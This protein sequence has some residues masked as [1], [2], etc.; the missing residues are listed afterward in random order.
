MTWLDK[1]TWLARATWLAAGLWLLQLGEPAA[2]APRKIMAISQVQPNGVAEAAGVPS[3][4]VLFYDISA[5]GSGAS[6]AFNN[7]P[8]FSVWMGY[9]IFEGEQND[10]PQGKPFGN[11]EEFSA[12]TVNP[13]N[14]TMYAVAFDSGAPPAKDDVGDTQGDFDLYRIDYQ[15]ILR[16]FVDNARSPGVV[17]GPKT[18]RITSANEQFLADIGSPLFDGAVDGVANNVPH[19]SGAPTVHLPNAFLKIGEVGRS[20]KPGSSFFDY[21][22]D[23]VDPRTLVLLD[24]PSALT[25][26]KDFHVRMLQRTST[27]PGGAVAPPL[28]NADQ[29]GGYNG[30]TTQSWRST[31]AGRFMLDPANE[32]EPDGWAL[33]R[34]DGVLGVWVNDDDGGGDEVAFFEID[35]SGPTPVATRKELAGTDLLNSFRADENPSVDALSNDGE[36][37]FL[38]VDRQGNLVIVESGFFD[39][40]PQEAK[41]LI[42]GIESYDNSAGKV[43]P[44]G[45]A[46]S[47]GVAGFDSV[48]PW[49]TSPQLP[50]VGAIDNDGDVTDVRRIAYDKGTG[51]LYII[52][53]D[54]GFFE[55]VYVFDPATGTIVY[56]E[57][58]PF[59]VGLIN[60]DTQ[61]IFTRGDINDDGRVDD[62]DAA[63]LAAAVADP[64]LGG[65][66]PAAVGGEWYDL[67]GDGLLT[68][69]DL[70]ELRAIRG[71]A[72]PGDFNGDGKANGED[73]AEWQKQFGTALRGGDLLVWQRAFNGSPPALTAVP[74]PHVGTLC[75][76]LLATLAGRRRR[77]C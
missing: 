7:Q 2:A 64:T 31:V 57:L 16:D 19:P 35:L 70:D 36:I 59:D 61:L 55:D 63:M 25:P 75:V 62:A 13:A 1:A 77:A 4:S 21:Q 3:D 32:S 48:N 10:L 73:Y 53:Q 8:L 18:L 20:Q 74:E 6:R 26:E 47:G 51:Y 49:T 23:F 46:A 41:I 27:A 69:A 76:G 30:N 39:V 29:E 15:A 50:I 28:F 38:A 71:V 40:P 33:V 54:A 65:T 44:A 68:Q 17:Y 37:D 42:A 60:D 45:Y 22:L 5:V 52:D 72:A 12:I 58:R 24:A 34:R 9:E 67:T 11:R 56:S 43:A 66:V 14:G